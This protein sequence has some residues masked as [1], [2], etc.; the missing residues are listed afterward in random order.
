MGKASKANKK[1][2]KSHLKRVVDQRRVEQK[3]KQK[4]AKTTK[5]RANKDMQDDQEDHS[6]TERVFDDLEGFLNESN[7]VPTQKKVG[8]GKSEGASHKNDL[9]ELAEKDPEFYKYLKENDRELLDFDPENLSV[10]DEDNDDDENEPNPNTT[11]KKSKHVDD[12]E[13]INQGPIEITTNDIKKWSK[14]LAEEKSLKTLKKILQAFASAVHF[15]DN[16]EGKYKYSVTD[17]DVF[18]S[19]LVV[20]LTKVPEV[21][22]HHIP[23]TKGENGAKST[24][25]ENKKLK[26]LSSAL[27]SHLSSLTV[28]L[29]TNH[30]ANTI[31]LIL[32]SVEDLVPYFLSYRNLVKELIN[33]IVNVWATAEEDDTK[34]AA[35]SFLKNV[36]ETYQKSLLE[37]IL[38][39]SYGGIVKVSRR[40]TIHTMPSINLQKNL[41]ATLY[42]IDP[43]VCYQQGFQFIRQLAIHLRTSIINKTPDTYKAVYNWQYAHS[44]DFWSR[45]LSMHCDPA[46]ESL[47][48]K[49]SPLRDLI[50]PLV[51]VT[52]GAIRLIPTP[53]YFP[54]RFYLIRSL[55]RLSQQTGVYIPLAPLLTEILVS[56]TIS[57]NG[58]RSTLRP[59]DFDHNIRAS[60]AYLGTRVYQDVVCEQFVDLI[61]EFFVLH[62][63]SIAFPELS[64]PVIISLK[65]FVKRSSNVKFN[66]QL[67]KMIEK[68][69]QNAKFIEQKRSSVDFGP[70]NH[71]QVAGFLKEIEWK[72]T[73]LGGYVVVQREIREERARILRESLLEDAQDERREKAQKTGYEDDDDHEDIEISEDEPEE[74]RASETDEEMLD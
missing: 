7:I 65:R 6:D 20:T 50:H 70:T 39:A 71:D 68:L 22:R 59:M 45:V 8:R 43:V 13:E 56:T 52:L 42:D 34:L 29:K 35:F 51:Q 73:P 41:A 16:T 37:L 15:Q 11:N 26:T 18:N 5:Q 58:K 25:I 1:F 2:K 27:R 3:Y 46:K 60:K 57:K 49:Q 62:C 12:D 36:G 24:P 69:D 40:T 63:K 21:V 64:I 47:K 55:I 67:Q 74:A 19:L 17:P 44:L 38:K 61:G 31:V 66:K 32:R 10:E 4:I 14:S 23:L 30:S 54:L 72:N 33:T 53:Q 9:S 28:L 48:G